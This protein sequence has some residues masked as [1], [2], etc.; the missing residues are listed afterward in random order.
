MDCGNRAWQIWH[1]LRQISIVRSAENKC[2][3]LGGSLYQGE[4]SQASQL[5]AQF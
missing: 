4:L 2:L 3:R 1:W 5:Y